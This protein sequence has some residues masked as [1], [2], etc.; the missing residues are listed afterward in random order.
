MQDFLTIHMFSVFWG[1]QIYL[2][3]IVW[4][5]FIKFEYHNHLFKLNYFCATL[6]CLFFHSIHT[7]CWICSLTGYQRPVILRVDNA[8]HWINKL[9]CP[10]DS[11]L[12]SWQCYPTFEQKKTVS[13]LGIL[14]FG[15]QL[16]P[17]VL[18]ASFRFSLHPILLIFNFNRYEFPPALEWRYHV[19]GNTVESRVLEPLLF[20]TLKLLNRKMFLSYHWTL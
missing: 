4:E 17:F 2:W 5:F 12:S 9:C 6:S 11:D 15:G 20:L 19:Y 18:Y 8:I 16:W 10:L 14:D 1:F 7:H 13:M 3:T